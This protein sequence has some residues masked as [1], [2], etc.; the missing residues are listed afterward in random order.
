MQRLKRR[1]PQCFQD[2]ESKPVWLEVQHRE[3]MLCDKAGE[4]DKSLVYAALT[5]ILIF[6]QRTM[7]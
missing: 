6:I 1:K 3:G 2:R 5:R 4:A 7:V